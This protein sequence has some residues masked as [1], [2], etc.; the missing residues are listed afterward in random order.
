[1]ATLVQKGGRA[2]LGMDFGTVDA[3]NCRGF[4]P[5]EFQSIDFSKID[6]TEYYDELKS[7]AQSDIEDEITN[8]ITDVASDI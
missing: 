2:Q 5:E 6:L 3:P 4:T 7:R 1:M 8:V